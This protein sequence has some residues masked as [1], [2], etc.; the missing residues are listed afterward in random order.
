MSN[1]DILIPCFEKIKQ[2]YSESVNIFDV[3]C[4]YNT[5]IISLDNHDKWHIQDGE[6]VLFIDNNKAS[7][8]QMMYLEKLA[9][10]LSVKITDVTKLSKKD[11]SALINRLRKELG[12][13]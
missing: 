1:I 8:K 4:D 10:K 7:Y 2:H 9:E 3:K 6:A 12:E 5:L 13:V 11:A